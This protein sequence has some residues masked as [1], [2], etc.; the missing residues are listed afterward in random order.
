ML[1]REV[2]IKKQK[3]CHQVNNIRKIYTGSFYLWENCKLGPKV[4]EA[5][6]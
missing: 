2:R 1:S 3:T 4:M 5:D 6:V